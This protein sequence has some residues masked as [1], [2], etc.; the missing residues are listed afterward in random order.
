MPHPDPWNQNQSHDPQ[1]NRAWHIRAW[2][3][4][5]CLLAAL[6]ALGV[7]GAVIAFFVV[8]GDAAGRADW[9]RITYLVTLLLVIGGGLVRSLTANPGQSY[10]HAA[11]WI[12]IAGV[13]ALSY[14]FW[15][16]ISLMGQRLAGNAD[17][18]AGQVVDDTLVYIRADSGHFYI[19]ATVEGVAVLFLVDTGATD[20]VLS[21]RDAT[22][23]GFDPGTLVYNRIYKTANG[24]GRGAAV[25][26]SQLE[27]G[28]VLL[29]DV[30]ASVNAAEMDI[31]LLGMRF[32]NRLGG[33]EVRGDQLI[34]RP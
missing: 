28:T 8:R 17:P 31:S 34:L 11:I 7:V 5:G 12:V 32:L 4:R 21:P 24:Q 33:Y 20:I 27:I 29:R 25:R 10:R 14:S 22:R 1:H 9:A 15:Q 16:E 13:A 6:V 30:P 18:A 26:L 19:R 3:N 2:H 23:L